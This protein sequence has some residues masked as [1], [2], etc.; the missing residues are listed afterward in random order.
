[1]FNIVSGVIVSWVLVV[2]ALVLVP[3]DF[4]WRATLVLYL[5]CTTALP[6]TLMIIAKQLSKTRLVVARYDDGKQIRVKC[7][8]CTGGAQL[9]GR[10]LPKHLGLD[11]GQDSRGPF[12]NPPQANVHDCRTCGGRG[13][14]LSIRE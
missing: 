9:L 10:P 6:I 3:M 13:E 7:T 14:M 2:S 8:D 4:T 12:F 5:I 1:M 11:Q